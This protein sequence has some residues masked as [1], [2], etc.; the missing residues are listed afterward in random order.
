MTLQELLS[1]EQ[2]FKFLKWVEVIQQENF[3]VKKDSMYIL[4]KDQTTCE[5][6]FIDTNGNKRKVSGGGGLSFDFIPLA[7]TNSLMPVTGDIEF[8]TEDNKGLFSGD[9]RIGLYDGNIKITSADGSIIDVNP[10]QVLISQ[11][12][13]GFRKS[14]TIDSN[15]NYIPIQ[16]DTAGPG[17]VGTEYFGDNYIP[18]SFIQK[19]FSEENYANKQDTIDSLTNKADLIGGKVPAYQL[20]SYVDDVLEFDTFVNFPITGESGKL[21]LALDTNKLYR[22]SGSSYV[23]ITQLE[24]DN[25]QTI[26]NRG[27]TT[28]NDIVST[29]D[30]Q[31]NT[32]SVTSQIDDTQKVTFK[33]DN[34]FDSYDLEFP[35]W[36][37]TATVMIEENIP[38]YI[39]GTAG[40]VGVF[41]GPRNINSFPGLLYDYNTNRLSVGTTL[42]A[43]AALDVTTVRARNLPIGDATFTKNIVSKPDGTFGTIDRGN[44]NNIPTDFYIAGYINNSANS[45]K[46]IYKT[47]TYR[48]LDLRDY[49]SVDVIG[50]IFNTNEIL[51]IGSTF[52]LTI[53]FGD[54]GDQNIIAL[55]DCYLENNILKVSKAETSLTGI[56]KIHS[57]AY[58]EID[59]MLYVGSREYFGAIQPFPLRIVKIDPHTLAVLKTSNF[60]FNVTFRNSTTDIKIFNNKLY[61]TAGAGADFK[62]YEVHTN[63]I[64]YTEIYSGTSDITVTHPANTPFEIYNG[65]LYMTCYDATVT[66]S[67]ATNNLKVVELDLITKVIRISGKILFSNT[68]VTDVNLITHWL[69]VYNDK[70]LFSIIGLGLTYYYSSIARVDIKTLLKEEELVLDMPVTD[71]HSILNGYI[72]L[73]GESSTSYLLKPNYP[74]DAAKLLRI[75]PNNFTDRTTEIAVFNGGKGS[76]GSINYNAK[77]AI[78]LEDL[79]TDAQ[80]VITAASTYNLVPD[81]KLIHVEFIGTTTTFNLPIIANNNKL[82][83]LLANDGLGDVTVTANIVDVNS[84]YEANS[85]ANTFMLIGG[86]RATIYSINNRWIIKP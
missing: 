63:L 70:L 35:D 84:I 48:E 76:Y 61:I 2:C 55:R 60:P 34:I 44:P 26:T 39:N 66:G 54:S 32:L 38:L 46:I 19:Q 50:G 15:L 30:I 18:N 31:G 21:Y 71:D 25:L 43:T 53:N 6:I 79:R 49:F 45:S 14:I 5:L 68:L 52:Y 47:D 8:T 4:E 42:P 83:I 82:T 80:Q 58:N 11:G 56:G 12:V 72:Y 41:V 74:H 85:G 9:G 1:D 27:A 22:W 77:S 29:A 81:R 3:A 59:G 69:T 10:N 40:Q 78:Q 7:G 33:G 86:S 16:S 73:N 13:G 62:A 24:S 64:D 20:P 23:D 75:N 51:R 65:K 57:F 36:S 67:E 28:D 37:G 17:L